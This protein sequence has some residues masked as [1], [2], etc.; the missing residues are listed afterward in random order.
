MK[1]AATLAIRVC[2]T[3][4]CLPLLFVCLI[5]F[6][7]ALS[8]ASPGDLAVLG[9]VTVNIQPPEAVADGARWS[10]NGGS[11][12]ASGIHEGS[13]FPG[14]YPLQFRNLPAWQEPDAV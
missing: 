9:G 11:E 3:T 14:R 7:P 8:K 1:Y 10:V 12:R 4:A 5:L 2:K 6:A 13:L